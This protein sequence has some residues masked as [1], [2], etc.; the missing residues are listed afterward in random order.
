MTDFLEEARALEMVREER[1]WY[2]NVQAVAD[3]AAKANKQAY[4]QGFR[5]GVIE[6]RKQAQERCCDQYAPPV[7]PLGLA[8]EE[9]AQASAVEYRQTRPEDFRELVVPWVPQPYGLGY[10]PRDFFPSASV[11]QPDGD[12][13]FPG[14]AE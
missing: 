3:L 12:G 6:G 8:T 9:T 4:W 2:E 13:R 10:T 7:G 11:P 5:D 1:K 14:E